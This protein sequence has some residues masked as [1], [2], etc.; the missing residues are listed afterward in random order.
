MIGESQL[1][2]GEKGSFLTADGLKENLKTW[3]LKDQK[4]KQPRKQ[5]Y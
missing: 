4:E 3:R 2:T 1:S 5:P